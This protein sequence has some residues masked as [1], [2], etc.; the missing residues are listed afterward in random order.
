MSHMCLRPDE[1]T[2]H[3]FVP[4]SKPKT[5]KRSLEGF[6]L[7]KKSYR[8]VFLNNRIFVYEWNLILIFVFLTIFASYRC[9]AFWF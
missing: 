4:F 3:N 5:F 6:L 1:K 7:F 9:S 8:L 2:L